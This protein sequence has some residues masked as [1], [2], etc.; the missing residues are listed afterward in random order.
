MKTLFL[1]I[2]TS[3]ASNELFVMTAKG[4]A[5][6]DVDVGLVPLV[7]VRV[8]LALLLTVVVELLPFLL[9]ANDDDDDEDR[10]DPSMDRM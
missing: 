4:A 1:S 10:H 2:S 7:V 9:L 3:A 6:T 5:A 8:A